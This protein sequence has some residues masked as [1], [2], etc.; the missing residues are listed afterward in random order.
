MTP[1]EHELMLLMF[2]KQHE[3]IGILIDVLKSRNILTSDDDKAFAHVVHFDQKRLLQFTV[4]AWADYQK[5][6]AQ[7]GITTG[8]E[9][10]PPPKPAK[11]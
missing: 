1:Q 7:L 4:Q 11:T 2:A 6:A 8:L 9:K 10:G 5:F 3:A